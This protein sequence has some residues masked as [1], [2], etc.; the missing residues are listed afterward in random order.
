MRHG[1][2]YMTRKT[3]R[4]NRPVSRGSISSSLTPSALTSSAIVLDGE[5]D[6]TKSL[7]I[8]NTDKQIEAWGF[9]KTL[10]ELNYGVGTWLA[11]AVSRCRLIAAELLPGGD[12]PTPIKDG[13]YADLM[14]S[15]AGGIGGQASMLK[16]FAVHLSIPGES[17]LIGEDPSGQGNLET[18]QWRVYSASEVKLVKRNPNVYRIQEYQNVWKTLPAESLVIRIW[19]PDDEYSWQAASPAIAALPILKEI[20]FWNRYIIAILLSRLALNGL[21]LIPAEAA[22]PVDP[23]FKD[24]ADPFVAKL[25]ST[26]TKSIRNPGTAAAAIPIPIKVPKDL[27]ESFKHLTFDSKVEERIDEHRE[28]AIG[29]LA[30]T[31]NMPSEVLTGMGKVNHWGQWQLEESA[32]KLHIMPLVEVI[33]YGLTI[34]FMQPMAK[35]AGLNLRGPNGGQVV[36]WV[37]VT[38]LTQQPDRAAEAQAAYDRGEID[39]EALRRE[40]GFEETDKPDIAELRD[41]ILQKIAI[42]AGTD[43]LTALARLVGDESLAPAVPQIPSA[44]NGPQNGSQGVEN[45]PQNG[46]KPPSSQNNSPSEGPPPT[47]DNAAPSRASLEPITLNSAEFNVDDFATLIEGANGTH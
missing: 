32:I 42:G 20:D 6:I 27:I 29:R 47:R 44:E 35:A 31:L 1:G 10:G 21:L 16:K 43:A 5:S 46:Q 23:E 28:K 26:A 36:I 14:Q 24:A 41:M 15:L 8:Q 3:N 7:V 30:T 37:D 33:C 4:R 39:G 19:Y 40:S 34:G 17:Y 22:L 9:Y 11:N 13:P 25:I 12:E 18:M 2:Q 45:L 38:E